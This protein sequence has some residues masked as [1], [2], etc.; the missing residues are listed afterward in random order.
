M[1]YHYRFVHMRVFR[2]NEGLLSQ[3][4]VSNTLASFLTLA[5]TLFVGRTHYFCTL[6]SAITLELGNSGGSVDA[7]IEICPFLRFIRSPP[8]ASA[9]AIPTVS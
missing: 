9:D 4:D 5:T 6:R 1:V 8:F 3:S 2:L 7:H